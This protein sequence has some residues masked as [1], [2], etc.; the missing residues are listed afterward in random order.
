MCAGLGLVGGALGVALAIGLGIQIQLLLP[1]STSFSPGLVLL[2]VT[3]IGMGLGI[4]WLF[5][6]VTNQVWS[7]LIGSLSDKGL[8]VVL[9]FAV[10][11]SL[12]Q[13]L[14]FFGRV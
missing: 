14:L 10:F 8:Q 4:S 1:A 3:A 2:L 11:T 7:G 5:A 9:V 13:T 12:L 6:Q